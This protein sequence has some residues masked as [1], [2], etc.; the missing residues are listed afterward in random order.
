MKPPCLSDFD[1]VQPCFDQADM[2]RSLMRSTREGRITSHALT[3]GESPGTRIPPEVLPGLSGI[4]FWDA[5]GPQG[6]G[7]PARRNEGIEIHF[8]E[9]GKMVVTVDNRRFNLLPGSLTIT[10]PWQWQKLGDPNVGSGRVHWLTLDVGVR[11]PMQPWRWPGWLVLTPHDLAELTRK[12]DG[13]ESPVWQ[14]IP[15]MAHTFQQISQCVV[16][17]D[18]PHAVSRLAAQLNQLFVAILDAVTVPRSID[19]P[20]LTS[21]RHKV[22]LFLQQLAKDPAGDDELRTLEAMASHCGMG[23]TSFTK[24]TRE[25]VNVAPMEYLK[26]CR[27]EQA[28]RQ[29][30]EQPG[31]SITEISYANGFNS[32]QYFSTCFRRQFKMSPTEYLERRPVLKGTVG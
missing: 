8:L 1:G 4:G 21:R 13:T 3:K 31:R 18:K 17:W 22:E 32:S 6:W 23:I 7:I 10:R 14:S 26:Q 28:A 11:R 9:T 27:L 29:L 30:L 15:G 5:V 20:R 16:N 12:L 25:L 24:F 2:C 19:N